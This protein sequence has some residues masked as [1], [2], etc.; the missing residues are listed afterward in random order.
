MRQH[1]HGLGQKPGVSLPRARGNQAEATA[2]YRFLGN[3]EVSWDDV[4]TAHARAS[5]ARMKERPSVLC[6][7]DTTELDV[8]RPETSG[9]GMQDI[10]VCIDGM[11]Y[12]RSRF[13]RGG[14]CVVE[15]V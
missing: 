5:R 9:L 14:L 1:K 13:S 11:R 8:N 10:T 15:L 4:L 6:L 7:Q 2:A 12:M 3:D